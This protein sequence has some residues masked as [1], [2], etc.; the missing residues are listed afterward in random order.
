MVTTIRI[1]KEI[2]E[3]L[4]VIGRKNQTYNDILKELL[5]ER[6]KRSVNLAELT[7]PQEL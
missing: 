5:K 4:R 7:E 1:E 2:R 6:K 3:A